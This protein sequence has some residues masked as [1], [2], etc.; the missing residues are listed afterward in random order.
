FV[1]QLSNSLDLPCDVEKIDVSSLTTA[2]T[3]IEEMARNARLDFL[4]RIARKRKAV[5]IAT[6]HHQDDQVET[7]L[8]HLIR[9]TGLSGLRG[10]PLRRELSPGIFLVR[11]L[12]KI[13]RQSLLTALEEAKQPYCL[14]ASNT[15]EEFTRNRIRRQLLPLLRA[16]FNPRVDDALS[17]LALQAAEWEDF[18]RNSAA[19]FLATAILDRSPE[20]YRLRRSL[21][22]DRHPLLQQEALRQ[23]WADLQW[24]RQNMSASHWQRA[25]EAISNG[26]R[27]D[28]PGNVKLEVR[29]DLIRL[30][31][32]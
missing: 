7:L 32:E 28:F 23:L 27:Q 3:G 4:K 24:P 21:W 11:P 20:G 19:E 8:H 26:G 5:W 13:L 30:Y 6:A 31:R 10:I 22:L 14:D 15:S 16:E 1:A 29:D 12:L 2:G 25:L 9:G 17:R 18:L